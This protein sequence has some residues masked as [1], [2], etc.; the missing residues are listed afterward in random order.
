MYIKEYY[1]KKIHSSSKLL[2]DPNSY[3][4]DVH[5]YPSKEF[6]QIIYDT[7]KGET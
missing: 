2:C 3:F 7:L 4:E 5:H 6:K 1:T